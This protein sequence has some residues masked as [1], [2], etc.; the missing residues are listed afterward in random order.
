MEAAKRFFTHARAMVGHAPEKVTADGH[1]AYPR[2]IREALGP[3]VQPRSSHYMNNRMGRDCR[4]IQQRY[5]LMRGV[6]SFD[7][8][9]RFC[10][11]HDDPRDHSR[12]RRNLNEADVPCALAPALVC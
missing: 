2:A 11:A 7:A 9:A 4:G 3:E 8:A 5:Y 12:Y 6:G 1:D 10:T